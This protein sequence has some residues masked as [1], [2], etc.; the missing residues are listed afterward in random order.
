MRIKTIKAALSSL[1]PLSRVEKGSIYNSAHTQSLWKENGIRP[2]K[3]RRRV[4]SAELV[5]LRSRLKS[6]ILLLSEVLTKCSRNTSKENV[7]MSVKQWKELL[8]KVNG[9]NHRLFEI[10]QKNLC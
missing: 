5:A 4:G 8:R 1:R 2:M 6:S 9:I 7:S 3:S 10:L